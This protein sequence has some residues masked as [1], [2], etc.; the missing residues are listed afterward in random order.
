ML[1]GL[2]TPQLI[3]YE[4]GVITRTEYIVGILLKGYQ[5]FWVAVTEYLVWTMRLVVVMSR[6]DETTALLPD[7]TQH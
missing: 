1:D 7:A 4:Y 6:R 2:T 3:I 5:S